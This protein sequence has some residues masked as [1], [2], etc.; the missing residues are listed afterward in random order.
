[1][2]N[3]FKSFRTYVNWV[4]SVAIEAEQAQDRRSREL[5]PEVIAQAVR[6]REEQAKTVTWHGYRKPAKKIFNRKGRS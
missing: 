6:E 4:D 5:S 3:P 1:M 2:F